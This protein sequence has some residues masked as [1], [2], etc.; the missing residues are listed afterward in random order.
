MFGVH[1]ALFFWDVRRDSQNLRAYQ[2]TQQA[3]ARPATSLF[4]DERFWAASW[5]AAISIA[6]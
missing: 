6:L 1:F 4:A 2:R 3:I 5:A